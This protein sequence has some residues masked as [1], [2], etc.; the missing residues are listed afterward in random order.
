MKSVRSLSHCEFFTLNL[1]QQTK[2]LTKPGFPGFKVSAV[3]IDKLPN[4][5][6]VCIVPG[7]NEPLS[8]FLGCCLGY[9]PTF[10]S[11][12]SKMFDLVKIRGQ[13]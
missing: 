1:T 5:H 9:S 13:I 10:L 8:Q 12:L 3:M 11:I 2:I 7:T 6:L 4:I